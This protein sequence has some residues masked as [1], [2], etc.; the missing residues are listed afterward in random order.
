MSKIVRESENFH[1]EIHQLERT[2]A[3]DKDIVNIQPQELLDNDHYLRDQIDL[4]NMDLDDHKTNTENPHL[5]THDQVSPEAADPTKADEVRHKHLSDADLKEVYDTKAALEEHEND[6]SNPHKVTASQV[7]A[8]TSDAFQSH[9]DDNS[10]PHSVSRT[11]IGAASNPHG[12]DQHSVDYLPQSGGSMSGNLTIGRNATLRKV[13]QSSGSTVT[14]VDLAGRV[15]YAVYNDL[16]EFFPAE[17]QVEPGDVVVWSKEGV[18]A[19]EQVTHAG[20]VGVVSDTFGA[21]LGG[22]PDLDVE[23]TIRSG[24]FAPVAIAGRVWVKAVGPVQKFD[25]L[26]TSAVQGHARRSVRYTQPHE[27]GTVIGKALE[28]LGEGETKRIC[29]LVM[30]R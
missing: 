23:E 22:D 4:T 17:E 6:D 29:M 24:R 21:V 1:D 27:G 2:H 5:V 18:R 25:L 9:V 28:E 12:N 15:H 26:E 14:I 7:G 8:P 30:L 20:V 10:N 19:C 13:I 16:A 3:V 11:Q